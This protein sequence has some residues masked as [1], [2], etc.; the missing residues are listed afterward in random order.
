MY[1]PPSKSRARSHA[2]DL[3]QSSERQRRHRE[4][5]PRRRCETRVNEV[6]LVHTAHKSCELQQEGI[7]KRVDTLLAGWALQEA[8]RARC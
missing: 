1:T 3:H 4:R 8:R 2:F 6:F 7:D 5:R